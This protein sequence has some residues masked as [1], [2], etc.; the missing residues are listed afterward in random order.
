MIWEGIRLK[1][2]GERTV[3]ARLASLTFKCG[4]G[5]PAPYST[6]AQLDGEVTQ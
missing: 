1:I 5:K 6:L 2:K 3:G 4:S